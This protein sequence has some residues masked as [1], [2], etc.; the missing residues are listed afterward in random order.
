MNHTRF[1]KE[2]HLPYWALRDKK[3]TKGDR[4]ECHMHA[5]SL[6]FVSPPPHR[7][8]NLVETDAEYKSWNFSLSSVL[9]PHAASTTFCF[10]QKSSAYKN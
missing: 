6:A 1:P 10:L 7:L 3:V 5:L 2:K 9:E 4:V 8:A